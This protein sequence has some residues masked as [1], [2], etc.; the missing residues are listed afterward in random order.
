MHGAGHTIG[1]QIVATA[2]K[3]FAFLTEAAPTARLVIQIGQISD[4]ETGTP[5]QH[6]Y[7]GG[8]PTMLDTDKMV[9]SVL[10]ED[11]HGAP[12]A[13]TFTWALDAAGAAMNATLTPSADT[14]SAELSGTVLL[15]GTATVTATDPNGLTG[16]T[17]V[18]VTS[19]ATTQL[20]LSQGTPTPQ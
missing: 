13:D 10:P 18:V 4:Q 6:Q 15:P 2:E 8:I 14:Q 9:I 3:F 5:S 1:G 19:G 20:V 17:A 11:S 7:S 12:T 16:T